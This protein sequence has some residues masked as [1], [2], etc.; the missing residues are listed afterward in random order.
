MH[1]RKIVRCLLILFLN[2]WIL[3]LIS[4]RGDGV[5][6]TVNGDLEGTSGFTSEIQ[7]LF[8]TNC[9][10]CH[11]PGGIGYTRTGGNSNNGL[12]LTR[13]N[14]HN[15]LVDQPTFEEPDIE[16]AKRVTPGNPDGSYL[17]Q[18][19]SSDAPKF[20][21]RMPLDGPPFLTQTEIQLIRD[22]ISAGAPND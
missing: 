19:I 2:V 15:A 20:G 10:R 16:P 3:F 11:S 17:I 18:K 1:R 8:D 12:D 14:A 6:L 21:S 5:G 7:P 22:W 13:G 9:I 4:C